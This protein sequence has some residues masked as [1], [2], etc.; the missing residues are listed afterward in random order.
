[1]QDGLSLVAVEFDYNQSVDLAAVDAQNALSKIRAKLPR[2]IGEPQV[3]KF[4]TSDRPVLTVGLR[5]EN[6][7]EVRRLAEDVLAPELQRV[8][9]VAL[10]DVFGGYQ[11]EISVQVDRNRLEAYHLTLPIVVNAVKNYNVSQ[12]AGQ[13][14]SEGRQ[15]TFRIDEQSRTMQDIANIPIY[16]PGG[17]RV[18]VSDIATI[19]QGSAED[20]SRFRVNG[21]AA[22]AIQIFKQDDAN[23]VEV[24][25]L[26]QQKFTEINLRYPSLEI[27][28]GEESASFTKQVVDNM[29]GSVWQ[30][31]FL[32]AIIIFLF[33]GSFNRGLV[34]A[35]SMPMSFLLTFA[36]M[37]LF[38]IEVN[39]VTL[40][41][42]ILA[43]GMVVD[44]SV[45]VLE[46]ITRHY[47]EEKLT[48]FEAAL[49]GAKE[50]QFAVFAGNAT[51]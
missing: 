12:P 19:Q 40:T 42:I 3:L 36:G 24:V 28:E 8:S 9:G 45:V 23:T 13:I 6:L 1:S 21:N 22:I 14:R 29:L 41:A 35:I 34:V 48:P 5:G 26:S 51:T 32:A 39:M 43:V 15:F 31:L 17:K 2:E 20:Q 27:I 16:I 37:K 10:V 25:E 50:I 4:S 11:P 18:R 47:E 49:E 38:N 33:L 7:V 44:A 46:N 30:A